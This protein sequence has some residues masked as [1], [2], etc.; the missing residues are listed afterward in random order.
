M[1][2][3]LIL[4]FAEACDDGE[5]DGNSDCAIPSPIGLQTGCLVAVPAPINGNQYCEVVRLPDSHV[6][7]LW[8][9]AMGCHLTMIA[10]IA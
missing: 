10:M 6:Y 4:G 7:A 5:D 9:Q 3:H 8:P 1:S 2:K